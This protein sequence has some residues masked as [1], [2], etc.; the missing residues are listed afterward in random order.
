MYTVTLRTALGQLIDRLAFT[1]R[2]DALL[3]ITSGAGSHASL[4]YT[5][6]TKL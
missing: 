4:R 1:S 5:P 3:T 6:I 2:M